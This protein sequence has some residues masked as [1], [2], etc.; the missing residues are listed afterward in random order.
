MEQGALVQAG[1]H[2]ELMAGGADTPYRKLVERQS[3]A[4]PTAAPAAPAAVAAARLLDGKN[5]ID[6]LLDAGPDKPASPRDA[7][8][9]RSLGAEVAE[10][11]RQLAQAQVQQAQAQAPPR[12][13]G[14]L[15]RV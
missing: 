12:H 4:G 10:L 6:A 13:P 9:A 15:S 5:K 7:A 2:A 3:L 1:T 14:P 11:R 8:D